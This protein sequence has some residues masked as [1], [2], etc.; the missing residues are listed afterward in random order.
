MCWLTSHQSDSGFDTGSDYAGFVEI[1]IPTAALFTGAGE[2][3]D[4]CY[5]QAC[6]NL[7]NIN[8][9]ALTVNAKAAA[10]AAATLANSLEGAPPRQKTSSNVQARGGVEHSSKS[11]A[12]VA[13]KAS[14]GHTC[15]HKGKKLRV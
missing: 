2:P 6:D 4:A 3:W 8:W 13:E 10:R 11:W 14:R 1:G 9:E 12:A 15:S 7:T 5:H